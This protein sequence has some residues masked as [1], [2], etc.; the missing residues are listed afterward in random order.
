M[1]KVWLKARQYDASPG[2]A[3]HAKTGHR[4]RIDRL[5]RPRRTARRQIF[6]MLS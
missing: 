2:D 1:L 6:F 4:R 3:D 5:A